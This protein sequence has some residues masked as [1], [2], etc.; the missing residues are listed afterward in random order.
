VEPSANAV[1]L[2]CMCRRPSNVKEGVVVAAQIDRGAS[3]AQQR[4][5]PMAKAFVAPV[6]RGTV[7]R[8]VATDD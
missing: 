2:H 5:E 1:V 3:A 6:G 8:I 4:L 7:D